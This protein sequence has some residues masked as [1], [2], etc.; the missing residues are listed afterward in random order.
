MAVRQVRW[1]VLDAA[2]AATLTAAA[3]AEV[4]LAGYGPVTALFAAIVTIALNWRRTYPLTVIVVGAAAWTVPVLLGLVP[5]E[6]ALTH[7]WRC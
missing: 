7:W 3:V 4:T 6:A 5:S 2:L 1:Q